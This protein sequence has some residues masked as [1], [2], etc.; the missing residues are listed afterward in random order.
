[1]QQD[2]LLGINSSNQQEA[3]IKSL[4][5]C[6]DPKFGPSVGAPDSLVVYLGLVLGN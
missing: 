1:M 6:W 2:I 5:F 4:G 3:A